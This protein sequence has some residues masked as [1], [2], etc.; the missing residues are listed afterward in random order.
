R[1]QSH[2]DRR[3][4]KHARHDRRQVRDARCSFH[5][6]RQPSC[7]VGDDHVVEAGHGSKLDYHDQHLVLLDE[8]I[9]DMADNAGV[10]DGNLGTEFK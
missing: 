5:G 4:E 7:F 9:T 8:R 3:Q 2:G 1:R 6:A 10:E